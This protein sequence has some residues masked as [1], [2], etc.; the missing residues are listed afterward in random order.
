MYDVRVTKSQVIYKVKLD[1][2]NGY[3]IISGIRN[4]KGEDI[5]VG[6]TSTYSE[7]GA[8]VH[9]VSISYD[10]SKLVP[11]PITLEISDYPTVIKKDVKFKLK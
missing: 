10:R 4:A 7:E 3:D 8:G 5:Y 1:G 9:E 2:D 11:G 6:P